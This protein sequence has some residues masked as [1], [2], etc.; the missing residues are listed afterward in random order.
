MTPQEGCAGAWQA[1]PGR[2]ATRVTPG[3]T[4]PGMGTEVPAGDAPE[5]RAVINGAFDLL[6]SLHGLGSARVSE[7]QRGGALPRTTVH[8][9]LTHLA[10]VGAVERPAGDG[11]ARP[12]SSSAPGFPRIRG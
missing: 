4:L 9:L 12:S 2:L 5:P 3:A 11:S 7:L 10:E 8:R 6:V 1:S